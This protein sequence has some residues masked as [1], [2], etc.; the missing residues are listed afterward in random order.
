MDNQNSN[1]PKSL[2]QRPYKGIKS[3]RTTSLYN[4]L[5]ERP[6]SRRMAAT[7]LGYPD[8]TYMVTRT[9]CEWI[10]KG[11]AQVVGSIRCERSTRLVEGITTNPDL[12]IDPI[13]L[14]L[15]D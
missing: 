8:Q 9:I 6:K 1:P 12:F 2:A 5:F 13:Q 10:K 3:E 7:E 14:V 4:I 15:F 11:K